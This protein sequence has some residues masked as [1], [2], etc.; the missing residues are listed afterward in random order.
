MKNYHGYIYALLAAVFNAMIGIFSV[1]LMEAGL[2]PY[3]ISFYK[4]FIS[5]AILTGWLTLTGQLRQWLCY[6]KRLWWQVPVAAFFGFFV[7]YF[8]ETAAY[9]YEKVTIVVFMLLG[10][11]VITTFILSSVIEKKGLRLHDSLCC[12]LAIGGLALIF[13]VNVALSETFLGILFALIAGV[14]YGA[15]LTLSPK[16]K[17]GSGFLPVNSLLLCGMLYLFIPFASEGI[18]LISDLNTTLLLVLLALLPTIGG[19][20]CTTKALTLLQS[21]SVQLLELSEPLLALAFSFLFLNQ[22]I[23]FWQITGGLLLLSSIFIN[24]LVN[25]KSSSSR[26]DNLG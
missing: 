17:I 16:F 4:C 13:G 3:A 22:S 6:M 5:C 18:V 1:K 9:N 23:T 20:L 7:L 11:A 26:A 15:F 12:T 10:S 14:G 24:S 25:A 21:K 19:F 2:T 8:F